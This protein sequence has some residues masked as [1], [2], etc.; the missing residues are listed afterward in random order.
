MRWSSLNRRVHRWASIAFTL[1]AG[2]V[3]VLVGSGNGELPE[4]VYMAP[5]LPL[6]LLL[7]T[8]LYLFVLP[9]VVRWRRPDP[10]KSPVTPHPPERRG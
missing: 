2:T 7:P 6:G 9:Y 10:V 1:A 3:A 4:W 8:G 5:L